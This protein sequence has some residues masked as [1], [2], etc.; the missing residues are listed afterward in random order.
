[1]SLN[2]LVDPLHPLDITV[3]D[4]SVEGTFDAGSV[5]FEDV[6]VTGAVTLSDQTAHGVAYIASDNTLES[7]VLTSGQLLIGSTGQDPVAASLTGSTSITVTPSAGGIQLSANPNLQ[8]NTIQLNATSG[9]LILGPTG[10]YNPLIVNTSSGITS[11][12]VSFPRTGANST[13]VVSEGDQSISGN[14][15]FTSVLNFTR[16]EPPAINSNVLITRSPNIAGTSTDAVIIGGDS[17]FATEYSGSTM[18][19]TAIAEASSTVNF[20]VLLGSG[21]TVDSPSAH[22]II[23]GSGMSIV[24]N[25]QIAIGNTSATDFYSLGSAVN[26]GTIGHPWGRLTGTD[27][28]IGLG[29]SDRTVLSTLAVGT[30]ATVALPNASGIA[31][32]TDQAS[33]VQSGSPEDTVESNTLVTLITTQPLATDPQG[34]TRFVLNNT[35]TTTRT[36]VT[37]SEYNAPGIPTVLISKYEVGAWVQI[38][39]YNSHTGDALSG[40]MGITVHSGL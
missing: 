1:M 22:N 27:L 5:A 17:D 7:K 3:N 29:S 12:T 6:L 39:I 25:G 19:G 30:L 14:K 38:T 21:I 8:V 24:G 23:I 32:V 20:S 33:I 40:P 34:S 13:I 4:L 31:L 28:S 37:I 36:M 26:L 35:F 16:L 2:Q 11:E 15:N 10:G 9:Q 18:V